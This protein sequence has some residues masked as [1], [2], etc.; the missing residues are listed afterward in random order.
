MKNSREINNAKSALRN[1]I[2]ISKQEAGQTKLNAI[3]E[4]IVTRI[5][6]LPQFFEAQTIACYFPLAYEVNLSTAIDKWAQTKRILLPVVDKEDIHLKLYR[7]TE[8]LTQGAFRVMEPD[9]PLFESTDEIDLIIVPGVA[10]DAEKNRMG[11][12][13]GFYDRFLPK[14]N[15]IKMGICFDFQLIEHIPTLSTDI[16]MDL[17]LTEKRLLL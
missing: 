14:L 11:Y 6:S 17:I 9:G 3:S 16:K 15:A 1:K 12:G 5:E 7:G 10:F 8:H 13:K 4:I 2:K